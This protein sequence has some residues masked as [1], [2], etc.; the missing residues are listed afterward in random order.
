LKTL[1]IDN[2]DSFTYNLYQLI[3][4]VNRV[5]PVV[6][7]NNEYSWAELKAQGFD[8]IVISPGPGRPERSADFGICEQVIL[9]ADIPVLGVCLGHQG[10]CHFTGGRI[11][12]AAKVMHGRIS[13]IHHSK[14]DLFK[15]LPSPFNAVRY[16]SLIATEITEDL[17]VTAFTSD[18]IPMAVRHK[19]RPMWGV[20]FHPE[21]ICS[22]F[23]FQ[24]LQNFRD[25]TVEYYKQ[26]SRVTQKIVVEMPS[27]L[28]VKRP[29]SVGSI[30][31]KPVLY[32]RRLAFNVDTAEIFKTL[33]GASSSAYW[34]DS[35]LSDKN[36]RFSFL[37]DNAGPLSESLRYCSVEKALTIT[38]GDT[39]TV[40]AESIFSYLKRRTQE[41]QC[42]DDSLPFDFNLGYVGYFGYELKGECGFSDQFK[43]ERPDACWMLADRAVAV[44]HEED[45][46]Y[47]VGLE[48]PENRERLDCWFNE[49]EKALAKLVN[50]CVR[51]E[52]DY[53]F[54][55]VH[56]ENS[57]PFERAL[58]E[59]RYLDAIARA[60]KAIQEGESYEIC[61]TN[62][63]TKKCD[64]SPLEVYLELRR[65]NP[66]P[67][68]SFL[69][70]NHL[71]ILCSS[72]ER[73]LTIDRHGVVETKPIKGTRK[74]GK[75][76]VE[77]EALV[78][79]LINSEKDRSENLMIVDLLR[80]DL[81][82]ICDIGSVDVKKLF[83]IESY[84]TVHQL[85]STV[86]GHLKRGKTAIDC[87]QA[88]FPGGSMTG[89]PKKRTLSILDE[90][91]SGAR[92]IY[93]GSIGYLALNGCADLNIVIRTIVLEDGVAE[94]GV[95]GAIVDLSEPQQELDETLLK[96]QA[97]LA[98]LDRYTSD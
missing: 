42:F 21:S 38:A 43:S 94:I 68:A 11:D 65:D 17:E 4:E 55:S 88:C 48:Y 20:Q 50:T 19:T 62:K 23:G 84:A 77:D 2:F 24:L 75:T 98:V 51:R 29:E 97:L 34:L 47:L 64:A 71:A 76:P 28:S 78:S 60:K 95:G 66:A 41:L 93:S 6:V 5:A 44:D 79:D 90:L 32:H 25:L 35:A 56:S 69:R 63:L 74:R 18:H 14:S 85:V 92:G 70:F 87:V 1:L 40:L 59:D 7:K 8:N 39:V 30:G 37:G 61:L 12:Y 45:V 57:Q 86:R 16:H 58:S 82:Q 9:D 72:P 13:A 26:H 27:D 96:G 53:S 91:E 49:T 67:Y 52:Q 89:A 83:A 80:N 46:I 36:A 73:F 31:I 3:A 81:G 15:S 22:E 54:L 33:Y 10:L